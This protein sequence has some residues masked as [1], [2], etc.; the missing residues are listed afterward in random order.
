MRVL[1]RSPPYF[2]LIQE[3]GLDVIPY[4][5]QPKYQGKGALKFCW[6]LAGTTD[7]IMCPPELS[8]RSLALLRVAIGAR[9]TAGEAD[10]P[11]DRL[12]S[13]SIRRDWNK[14]FLDA[15]EELAAKLGFE[16]PLEGP[17]I[18]ITE[19]ESNWAQ[20]VLRRSRISD[21]DVVVGVH[22][23]A[24]VP[25]K[26]WSARSFGETMHRLKAIFPNLSVISFGIGEERSVSEAARL[27]AE[28]VHW[29]EGTG[30]WTIRQ[31][32]AMLKQ[33]DLFVSG[34]TGLMHMAA[35]VGT[36]TLSIFGPTSPVRRAPTYCGGI[37]VAP[38]TSCHPCYRL[39]EWTGCQCIHTIQVDQVADIARQCL[40]SAA[41][42]KPG[43]RY[44]GTEATVLT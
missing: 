31:T 10:P 29:I 18:A 12:L 9:Y 14:S 26:S 38:S 3:E 21:A 27:S 22:C 2:E 4:Y 25:D 16:T 44:C 34:D 20:A 23:S 6:E 39:N 30:E 40:L 1:F 8:A 37:A 33:C 41:E 43:I 7:L 5:F 36:R 13:V 28:G 15:Q 32:L 35:A 17:S 11:W 24:A 42:A 19:T